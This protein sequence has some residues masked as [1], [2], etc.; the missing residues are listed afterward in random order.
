VFLLH[1]NPRQSR[2][3]FGQQGWLSYLQA[4]ISRSLFVGT[5]YFI[6]AF[7]SIFSGN[8][9]AARQPGELS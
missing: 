8:A 5:S 2:S 4:I 1:L 7:V 6:C 3:F 9:I